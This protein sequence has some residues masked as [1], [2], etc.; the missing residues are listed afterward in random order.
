MG[1]FLKWIVVEK[2]G[3]IWIPALVALGLAIAGWTFFAMI[4][5]SVAVTGTFAT[6][7]AWLAARDWRRG[8]KVL[9]WIVFGLFSYGWIQFMAFIQTSTGFVTLWTMGIIPVM[10][11]VFASIAIYRRN[12]IQGIRNRIS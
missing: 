4:V 8:F 5:G 9:A 1:N 12:H 10:G 2:K 6:A 7:A 3:Y 11:F